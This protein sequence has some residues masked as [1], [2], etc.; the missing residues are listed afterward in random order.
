MPWSYEAWF[1][2]K[3]REENTMAVKKAIKRTKKSAKPSG[4]NVK[5][6]RKA[7]LA[8]LKFGLKGGI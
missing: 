5:S 2:A 6:E 1:R 7:S 3:L 8:S 4:K